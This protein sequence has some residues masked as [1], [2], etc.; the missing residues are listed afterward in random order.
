VEEVEVVREDL[1]IFSQ[2][3]FIQEVVAVAGICIVA[4]A[5]AALPVLEV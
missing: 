1:M 2:I 5:V 3:L 4:V